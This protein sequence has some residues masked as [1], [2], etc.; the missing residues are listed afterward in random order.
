MVKDRKQFIMKNVLILLALLYSIYVTTAALIIKSS[1]VMDIHAYV[2]A[3]VSF[4]V[5]FKV[6][7]TAI[8]AHD[9]GKLLYI[10]LGICCLALGNLYFFLLGIV[11]AVPGDISVGLF[12]KICCYLFFIAALLEF[13]KDAGKRGSLYFMLINSITFILTATCAY[14]VLANNIYVLNSSVLLMD[15]FCLVLA[16][17]LV[18][19]KN[20][21]FFAC[22]MLAVAVL[23]IIS[24]IQVFAFTGV[25]I[26]SLSPLLYL[27]FAKLVDSMKEGDAHVC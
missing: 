15:V 27:L 18:P 2:T 3:I 9:K 5:S 13:K 12:A 25:F 21:R 24:A 1:L 20:A 4:L 10:V 22:L 6:M 11:R 14:A 7:L 19:N 16:S 26:K 8:R 17:G 23:D